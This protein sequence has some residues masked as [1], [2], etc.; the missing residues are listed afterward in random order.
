MGRWFGYRIGFEDLVRIFMPTD[1]ILWFEGV[2]KLEMDLRKD[3]EQNNEDDTK[4]LPRDA[5]IKLA[6]HT[7]ENMHVPKGLRKKFP[8]IC[9]PNKL[10]NTRTQLMSFY[11]SKSTNRI[12][13][14][15]DVQKKNISLVKRI[16]DSVNQDINA[17]L[18]DMGKHSVP[19][20]CR[21]TNTNYTDVNY[22][23]LIDLLDYYKAHEKI[24]GDLIALRGFIEKNK[25]KLNNWSLVLVNANKKDKIDAWKSDFYKKEKGIYKLDT[26][27]PISSL[28]RKS[29]TDGSAL[30]FKSILNQQ[31]DNIFDI[32]DEGNYKEYEGA[33]GKDGNPRQADIAK[34]YRNKSGKPMLLVYPVKT[35]NIGIVP[36]LYFFI[37]KIEGADKVRYIVRN[38]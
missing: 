38:K 19:D 12:I 34:K 37:P 9:D 27:E 36:L 21:N 16:F 10:R 23:Y 15:E 31:S 35:D 32:I 6:Y 30:Y 24:T 4:M 1:Q 7:N 33:T 3:F 26:N 14:D 2:Y 13:C 8:A 18:F 28:I 25:D 22:K 17:K 11:G 29:D 5:V 20:A